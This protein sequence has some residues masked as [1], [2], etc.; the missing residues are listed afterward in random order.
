MHRPR[1]IIELESIASLPGTIV[2]Y[3]GVER[4]EDW[5][6]RLVKGGRDAGTPVAIVSQCGW[7]EEKILFTTLASAAV[8]AARSGMVSPAVAIVGEVVADSGR[9][10]ESVGEVVVGR[11]LAGRR[12]L[13]ARPK[14]QS[15]DL[16]DRLSSLGGE[17][18]NAAAITIEPPDSWVPL[19]EAILEA[20]SFDWIVFSSVNGVESFVGRLRAARRDGRHLGTARLA[21]VGARTAAAIASAGL[22]C[23]LVPSTAY[24]AESLADAF[25][26]VPPKGRFLLVRADRGRDVLGR[27]LSAAGHHVREVVA[28]RSVDVPSLDRTLAASLD[29]RSAD[30]I[31]LTSPAIASSAI[32][33]FG[34]QL[35]ASR[36]AT[37]SPLTSQAVRQAGREPTVEAAAAT[38]EA[39][40][41][42]IV[43]WETES[44]RAK[45]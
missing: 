5:S 24:S 40:V 15:D 35:D 4:L 28:Y 14:G 43:A 6:L 17:C 23:D 45:P 10:P 11:P 42:A 1:P 38:I 13:I 20:A 3:M 9:P 19:D 25:A 31:V 21:A 26:A 44:S 29:R 12:I 2:F 16:V 33:L 36:I 39:I 41:A 32:R 8:D 37:I 30:W 27:R 22:A 7:E 18:L 34:D